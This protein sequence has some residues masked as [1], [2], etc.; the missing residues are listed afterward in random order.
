MVKRKYSAQLIIDTEGL[1]LEV[2]D[3]NLMVFSIY[4]YVKLFIS[5]G[6]LFENE[7]ILKA[8]ENVDNVL[9][10]STIRERPSSKLAEHFKKYAEFFADFCMYQECFITVDPYYLACAILAY[11]R[12][13]MGVAIIWPMELEMLTQCT[14][15]HFRDLYLI[16]ESK[17][18]DNFPKHAKS[19]NYSSQVLTEPVLATAQRGLRKNIIN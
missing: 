17:Y 11:T 15:H 19:Q 4:D 8:S 1:V 9:D 14:V 13:F 6:C 18:T 7:E 3:W 10:D 2:I 12:K 16:I 5:Q